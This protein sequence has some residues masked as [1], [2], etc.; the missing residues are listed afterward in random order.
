M[1]ET[2]NAGPLSG[3]KVLELGELVA[4]PFIGTLLGEFGAEVIKVERPGRGDVLRKF[5]PSVNGESLYWNVN[6]RNKK[7]VVL[8]LKSDAG[9]EVL[10]ELIGHCDVLINSLRPGTMEKWGL[11]EEHLRERFPQ[12]VIIYT[13]AYGRHGPYASRGGYDPVAQGYSG[14]STMTG[15]ADGAPMRAGGSIPTCDF[16][17]GVVGALGAVLGLYS[18]DTADSGHS[19]GQSVD[20]A[21]YDL[22]FRMTGPLLGYFDATGESIGR[23]G[24]HSLGGAP[25][26]H[27]KT[28]D[29]HWICMS[30]QNDEQFRRLATLIERSDWVDNPEYGSSAGRTEHRETICADFA[31]WAKT[32]NRGELIGEFDKVGLVAGP[33]NSV[34]DLAEDP[35]LAERGYTWVEDEKIGRYRA[36][37]IIPRLSDTPGTVR[38]KAPELGADTVSILRSMLAYTDEQCEALKTDGVLG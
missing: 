13:S 19:G 16:L 17:T 36:P 26:G 37:E 3:K 15:D 31:A 8:D 33:I 24:N 6:G 23:N 21:L 30:V 14:L 2:H 7:S 27:F 20:V 38:A 5:G 12:L 11:T 9:V 35:H 29:D 18:R 32:K 25:T 1:N 4:G 28:K 34:A 22:A 10:T